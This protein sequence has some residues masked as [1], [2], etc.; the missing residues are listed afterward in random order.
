MLQPLPSGYSS[1]RTGEER[2]WQSWPASPKPARSS[3]SI[4]GSTWR[5]PSTGC[6]SHRGRTF[7]PCCRPASRFL[8]RTDPKSWKPTQTDDL[9]TCVQRS[10]AGRIRWFNLY[11]VRL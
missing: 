8:N 6:R 1:A 2:P 11:P 9:W 4:P 5:T 3:A 7:T 10:F